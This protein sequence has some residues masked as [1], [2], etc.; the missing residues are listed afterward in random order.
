MFSRKRSNQINNS[1]RNVNSPDNV[2]DDIHPNEESEIVTT[3]DKPK[4]IF[5]TPNAID[6]LSYPVTRD[7]VRT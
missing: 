5:G 3:L 1:C 7:P 2:H 4:E 6:A